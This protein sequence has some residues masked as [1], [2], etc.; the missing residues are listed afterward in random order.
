MG[1]TS[2]TKNLGVAKLIIFLPAGIPSIPLNGV[3][4][5]I[6]YF[7]PHMVG[8]TIL[9]CCPIPVEEDNIAGLRHIANLPPKPSFFEPVYALSLIHIWSNR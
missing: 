9:S 3:N 5:S 1:R 7:L 4:H 2:I 8:Q 6:F